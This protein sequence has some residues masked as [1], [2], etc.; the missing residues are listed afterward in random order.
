MISVAGLAFTGVRVMVGDVACRTLDLRSRKG[1]T[2]S[3]SFVP[4][5]VGSVVHRDD[6]QTRVQLIDDAGRVIRVQRRHSADWDQQDV[7]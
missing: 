3:S 4:G 1:S 6:H 2:G 7:D 5:N